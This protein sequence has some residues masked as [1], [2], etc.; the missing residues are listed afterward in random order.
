M[1]KAKTTK[2][3]DKWRLKKWI[4]VNAPPSF[5]STPVAYVPMTDSEK[6]VGRLIE[7]TLYDLVKQDPQQYV[8][9][10][11]FRINKINDGQAISI[12]Y[13]HEYSRE[14][15]RSLVRRGSSMINLIKDY[16]TKDNYKVRIHAIA[17]TPN[18]INSSKKHGIRLAVYKVL[19]EKTASLSYDQFA[20]E[21]VLGKISSEIYNE[22]KKIVHLRHIG[23]KKTK[24]IGIPSPTEM[25]TSENAIEA[26]ASPSLS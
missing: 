21:A 10:L 8:I 11:K 2:V 20:Q 17:F 26:K 1:P 24:L 16:I 15:L 5:G 7:T 18:R 13:S 22:A 6:A 14:Y 12:L 4:I 25:A 3:R 19:K 23:L 9:K